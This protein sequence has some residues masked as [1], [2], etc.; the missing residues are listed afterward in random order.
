MLR[1]VNR[2]RAPLLCAAAIL[3][4]LVLPGTA[5]AT[6]YDFPLSGYWPMNEGRGQVVRD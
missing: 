6:G 5:S 1:C 4:A 3:A 2:H